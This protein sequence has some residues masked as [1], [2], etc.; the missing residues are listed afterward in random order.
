MVLYFI[1]IKHP[2]QGMWTYSCKSAMGQFI[3]GQVRN[4]FQKSQDNINSSSDDLDSLPMTHLKLIRLP[5]HQV[6]VN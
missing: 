5:D 6:H 2:Y 3:R 1:T 4:D